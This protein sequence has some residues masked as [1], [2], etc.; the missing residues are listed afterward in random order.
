MLTF[1]D[2]IST[3]SRN[4]G[5]DYPLALH[6]V[7]EDRKHQISRCEGL[8]TRKQDGNFAGRLHLDPHCIQYPDASLASAFVYCSL[9]A[10]LS[11][12]LVSMRDKDSCMYVVVWRAAV[13]VH[14]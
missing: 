4:V 7:P 14:I 5:K 10:K 1:G 2:G 3:L 9:D 12:V 8:K 11:T 6:N 13:L